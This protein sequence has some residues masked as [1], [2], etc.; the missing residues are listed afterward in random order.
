MSP[1]QFVRIDN[2]TITPSNKEEF[3]PLL[4]QVGVSYYLENLEEHGASLVTPEEGLAISLREHSYALINGEYLLAYEL[5]RQWFCKKPILL[6][7]FI[8]RVSQGDTSLREVFE[9][10]RVLT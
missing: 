3:I 10:I 7:V 1:P 5:G 4:Y 8:R 9:A 6:E 2:L